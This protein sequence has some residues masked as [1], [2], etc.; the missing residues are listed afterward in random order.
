MEESGVVV[1]NLGFY[2]LNRDKSEMSKGRPSSTIF[3]VSNELGFLFLLRMNLRYFLE[4]E[5]VFKNHI[6]K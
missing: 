3:L 6:T 1:V 5:N 2:T 4:N